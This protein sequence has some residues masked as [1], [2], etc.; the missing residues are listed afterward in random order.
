MPDITVDEAYAHCL[1]VA[2]QSRSSFLPAMRLLPPEKRRAILAVYAFSR[3][4]DD[5]ADDEGI[6]P[7]ERLRRFAGLRQLLNDACSGRAEDALGVA[8][9]DAIRRYSIPKDH[10]AQLIVG[11][12]SDVAVT[13]YE[14][15]SDLRGYCYRVASTVGLIG[16][17]IFGYEDPKAREF[18]EDLWIGMQ[19]VNIIRDLRE[20]A[21]R[22][23]IYLPLA[24]LREHGVSEEDILKGKRSDAVLRLLAFQAARA[25]EFVDRGGRVV[26][27]VVEDARRCPALLRASY[28]ALLDRITASGY[29]VYRQRIRLGMGEKI[30]LLFK[31][32]TG[33]LTV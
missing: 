7:D 24:E 5:V 10:F 27:L 14:T 3:A 17:E 11:C 31:A 13:R 4:C 1:R 29:D 8:L 33:R 6:T 16:L 12:E 15:F 22:G 18:G 2:K 28:R 32:W 25:R 23:R 30:R 21:A 9:A 19:L 26:P 20:D